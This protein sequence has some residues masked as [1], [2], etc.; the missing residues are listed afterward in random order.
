MMQMTRNLTAFVL[1]RNRN[2]CS[3]TGAA[4][5]NGHERAREKTAR[6]MNSSERSSIR[7][8]VEHKEYCHHTL[9]TTYSTRL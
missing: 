3:K 8:V 5:G 4:E 6:R 9:S 1:V 7:L 2:R